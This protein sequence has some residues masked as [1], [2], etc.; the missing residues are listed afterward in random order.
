[1]TLNRKIAPK[2]GTLDSINY[3]TPIEKN[4]G[5]TPFYAFQIPGSEVVQMDFVFN[6]GWSQQSDPLVANY[7][8]HLLLSG[9]KNQNSTDINEALDS[10]GAYT[11]IKVQLNHSI[12]TVYSTQDALKEVLE[13]LLPVI[14]GATYPEEDLEVTKNEWLNTLKINKTKTAYNAKKAMQQL[15]YGDDSPLGYQVEQKDHES[16]SRGTLQKHHNQFLKL[17]LCF[18]VISLGEMTLL[19]EISDLFSEGGP[20]KS[21]LSQEL[22]KQSSEEYYRFIH[23]PN[24]VQS[25]VRVSKFMVGSSH[26]DFHKINFV[27]TLFG[28]YF[29]SRLMSNIREEK[30]LTYGIHSSLS[31][32]GGEG[33]FTISTEVKGDKHKECLSEIDKEIRKL[34]TELV[35]ENELNTVKNY[36]LGLITKSISNPTNHNGRFINLRVKGLGYEH[37][38]KYIETINEIT[39]KDVLEISNTYFD[40]KTLYRVVATEEN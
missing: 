12:L 40:A 6:S 31:I 9:T 27:N 21:A 10:L 17:S 34:Q 1:M 28:G 11:S 36:T 29:G 22:I 19:E 16:I 26:E 3:P 13:I 30:G 32:E 39:S 4:I 20:N 37:L 2:L 25:A 18:V 7:A 8:M 5:K 24:A 35:S 23:V 14:E 15:L 38:Y 33:V